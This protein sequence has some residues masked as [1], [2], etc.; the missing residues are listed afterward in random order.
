MPY[1]QQTSA[2]AAFRRCF[3]VAGIASV[4]F[5]TLSF[6]LQPIAR[7]DVVPYQRIEYGTTFAFGVVAFSKAGIDR[8]EFAISGQGYS[9]STKTS[10]SMTLNTRLAHTESAVPMASWPGVYEYHVDISAD[11][12]T[13][14]GPITVTPTVYGDDAGIRTLSAVTLIVEGASS[15]IP[16]YA[17]V[18]SSTGNDGAGQADSPTNKF[19][20]LAAAVAAAQ[21]ANGGSS[22]GNMIYLEEGTYTLGSGTVSTSNEWLTIRNANGASRDNVIIDDGGSSIGGGDLVK[23]EGLTLYSSES[24]DWV[25]DTRPG[26]PNDGAIVWV[27]DCKLTSPGRYAAT[28][29]V[30]ANVHPL[31]SAEYITDTYA[32][33]VDRAASS[34]RLIRNLTARKIAEDLVRN[35]SGLLVNVRLDD[36]NNGSNAGQTNYW[37]SDG[38]QNF[39]RSMNN[40]IVYNFYG[41]D[42][43]YQ[44]LFIRITNT[45]NGGDDV[46]FVNVFME[47][48][49]PGTKGSAGGT[50]QLSSGSI[51]FDS[52]DSPH[53][54]HLLM[55]HCS[56]P[57]RPYAVTEVSGCGGDP[58][59]EGCPQ[60]HSKAPDSDAS[61]DTF[62]HGGKYWPQVLDMTDTTTYSNFGYPDIENGAVLLDR[63]PPTLPG[64]PAAVFGHR[65]DDAPDVGAV[66]LTSSDASP[67]LPPSSLK[68]QIAP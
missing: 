44:G 32:Y 61:R 28:S 23:F 66:E 53:W 34:R 31:N 33:D 4:V 30:E 56:F 65:R 46:A 8:V 21:S 39:L 51:Y 47:M 9:G 22:S 14:N 50:P 59:P 29:L 58:Q 60:W 19:Q 36:Q 63:L 48:R 5:S 64:V 54:N 37:H 38:Y 62:S 11:E 3:L 40:E 55:W 27:H 10:D 26:K 16:H 2:Q 13:S 52:N 12:F 6:A 45:S 17:I 7:T 42:M 68:V 41:T 20:T 35:V 15:S 67:P 43:H 49:E 24:F 18:N 25:I 57:T 1:S